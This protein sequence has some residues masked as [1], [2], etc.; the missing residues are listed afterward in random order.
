MRNKNKKIK[1][2]KKA[3]MQIGFGF[4]FSAFLII[5]FITFAIYVVIK[6][7]NLQK[8][9]QVE[10]FKDDLRDDIERMWKSTQGSQEVEYYLPKSIEQVCFTHQTVDSEGQPKNN[11][12][13]VPADFGGTYLESMELERTVRTN[14]ALCIDNLNGKVSFII[15]KDYTSTVVIITTI[16][17]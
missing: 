16:P 6:F 2:N 3:Q 15:K 17:R 8:Y 10:K 4:L 13:F 9:A 7:V 12:Y 1:N 5:I 11:L 14:G